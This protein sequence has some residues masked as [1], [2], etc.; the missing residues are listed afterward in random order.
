LLGSS[1]G[2]VLGDGVTMAQWGL[3]LLTAAA[4]ATSLPFNKVLV[5]ELSPITLAAS[6]AVLAFPIMW[7]ISRAAGHGLPS[8]RDAWTTSAVAAVLIVVT[9]FCA[10]AW[11]QQHIPSGL[12]GVLYAT[13]P[14]MT[15]VLAHFLL[16]DEP[17]SAA[18]VLGIALGIA[19]TLAILG[20]KP[21]AGV[22][23]SI[24]GEAVTLL[25]PLS[26]ALGNLYLKQRP[27][28]HPLELISGMFLIGAL[29]MVP[30]TVVMEGAPVWSLRWQQVVALI[31]LASIGTAVPALLN[32][33]LV[34]GAGATNASLVMFF[35]PVFA[36][37]FGVVLLGESVGGPALLGM[38]LI[39]SG[40]KI[41]SWRAHR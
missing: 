27:G 15:V 22:G 19:G 38:C 33:V 36:L 30:L 34:R 26:Y 40:S 32:Y 28:V 35:M 8:S 1:H 24:I 3:L 23:G 25:A 7:L 9:T 13:M 6:R 10:I 41:V 31:G 21:L 2:G 4:F 20:A 29:L 14:V 12:G 17:I 11:G 5:T 16:R 37:T 18:K 39:I